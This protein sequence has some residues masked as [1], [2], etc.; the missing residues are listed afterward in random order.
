MRSW[1]SQPLGELADVIMG[2]SP[3]GETY[4]EIGQGLP[5]FQGKAEFGELNPVARKWC[6]APKK[7]A[8]AGDI[9]ISVRAPV[10]PTNIA[11]ERCCIGRGLAAIRTDETRVTSAYIRYFLRYAEPTLAAL[12]QGST[13]AAIGRTE[14][15]SLLVPVPP[16]AEQRRVVD[17][18][19]RAEGIL[20]LRREAEKKAAELVPAMFLEMFGD[21]ATN[22]KEWPQCQLGDILES[23]D[24]GSSTKASSDGSGMPLI[25]M[26]NVGYDG[27][28]DLSDLKYV[29]LEPSEIEK[30]RLREGDILFNRTNSKELVGKTGLWNGSVEAVAASYFIRLRVRRDL[31]HPAY[32]WALMNSRHMKRILYATA[33]GAIGQANINSKELRAFSIAL[34]PLQLQEVFSE[35]CRDVASLCVEQATA[36]ERAGGVFNSMLAGAFA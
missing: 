22:P 24:Y 10:G 3:P 18:L 17:I 1:P 32:V 21:P 27:S 28:L 6:S 19:S 30:Y 14:I 11:S 5:F 23:A 16:L 35:R 34:P 26:G 8:H 25:R 36:T 33:R 7:I 9:L 29:V 13:F 12:G 31:V 20:R 2:Q 4:N 15:A